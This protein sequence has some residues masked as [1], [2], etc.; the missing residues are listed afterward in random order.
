MSVQFQAILINFYDNYLFMAKKIISDSQT[1][2]KLEL[3][4][5][6]LVGSTPYFV[7]RVQRDAPKMGKENC[8]NIFMCD[9]M[10]I[11][12]WFLIKAIDTLV[13]KRT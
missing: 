2:P 9:C 1:N 5:F 7:E 10:S 12:I 6:L 11:I 3:R 4:S 13:G 8:Y